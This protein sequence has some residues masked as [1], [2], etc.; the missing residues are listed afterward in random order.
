MVQNKYLVPRKDRTHYLLAMINQ[1]SLLDS[2]LHRVPWLPC[3]CTRYLFSNTFKFNMKI[4]S[5]F[6]IIFLFWFCYYWFLK[7]LFSFGKYQITRLYRYFLSSWTS[8]AVKRNNLEVSSDLIRFSLSL[9]SWFLPHNKRHV[10]VTQ[11]NQTQK[12]GKVPA[13]IICSIHNALS[14]SAKESQ[15]LLQKPR[16]LLDWQMKWW[17]KS[18][19][20][21][22]VNF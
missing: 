21:L 17:Y 2:I 14:R 4:K 5:T 18:Q 15:V 7:D 19:I 11:N 3:W 1:T 6:A 13:L 16:K 10:F 9:Q 22:S 20:M 12:K 8:T